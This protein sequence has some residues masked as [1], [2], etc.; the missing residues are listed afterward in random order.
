MKHR[1]AHVR[2]PDSDDYISAGSLSF[3]GGSLIIFEDNNSRVVKAAYGP[4][5]WLSF[6]WKEPPSGSKVQT[7]P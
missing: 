3:D 6:E 5:G 2:T 1:W 7:K 4:G